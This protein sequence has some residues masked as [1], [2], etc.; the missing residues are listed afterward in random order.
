MGRIWSGLH[1]PALGGG[2]AVEVAG[3]VSVSGRRRLAKLLVIVALAASS[4]AI[5]SAANAW[6]TTTCHFPSTSIRYD[7]WS[8]YS[9]TVSSANSW[10]SG[11]DVTLSAFS[12]S[13]PK[14][15]LQGYTGSAGIWGYMSVPSCSSGHWTGNPFI[16]VNHYYMSDASTNSRRNTITHEMGHALGVGHVSTSCGYGWNRGIMHP[17]KASYTTCGWYTPQDDDKGGV[18]ARY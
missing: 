14:I 6:V 17:T 4:L 11:T 8:Y 2:E 1:P 10:N 16:G 15:T 18:N 13:T 9:E 3:S 12:G 7:A 5:G